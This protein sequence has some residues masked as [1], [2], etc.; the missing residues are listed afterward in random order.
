MAAMLFACATSKAPERFEIKD[1]VPQDIPK[2]FVEKLEIKEAPSEASASAA[3][4]AA[5]TVNQSKP[6]QKKKKAFKYPYRRPKVE[7]MPIGEK[8]TYDISFFSVSA[9]TFTMEIM[10]YKEI[11]GRKVYHVMGTAD[12]SMVFALFYR[13]HDTVESYIDFDGLFSHRLQIEQDESTQ[14]RK[15]IE[16]YDHEK[17]QTFFWNRHKRVQS[18]YNETKEIKPMKRF[19]QD[20]LSALYFVR[21]MELKD[22]ETVRVPVVTEGKTWDADLKILRREMIN[23]ALG[24]MRAIVIQP[25]TRLDGVLR[26]A[27]DS[28]IWL[29]DDDRKL[30]LRLEAKVKIGAVIAAIRDFQPGNKPEETRSAETQSEAGNSEAK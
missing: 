27:G 2:E 8:A 20:T 12:S 17:A 24:R 14:T 7:H 23:T 16:I 4:A 15:S 18:D 9:G 1:E 10:P 30:L 28:F 21:P 25:E 19:S 3:A 6:K 5:A 13:L 29:S 26:K 22:G 11:A